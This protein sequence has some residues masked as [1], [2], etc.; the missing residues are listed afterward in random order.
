MVIGLTGGIGCG[1]S[2][3]AAF[4]KEEGWSVIDTDR[5]VHHLLTQD[6]E[7]AAQVITKLG[8]GVCNASGKLDKKRIADVVF[9][10]TRKLSQLEFLLHPRVHHHWKSVVAAHPAT[11]WIVELPLLFENNLESHFDHTVC[12]AANTRN[13]RS[14]LAKRGLTPQ[15]IQDRIQCQLPLKDK[16]KRADYVVFNNGSLNQLKAQIVKL[17]QQWLPSSPNHSMNQ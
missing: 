10:D 9:K 16:I 13:Q 6:A 4:F 14:Y 17:S 15:Q 12:I 3:A 8:T 1:K 2:T 5:I 11:P 7:I